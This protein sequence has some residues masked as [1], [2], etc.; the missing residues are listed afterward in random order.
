MLPPI[1]ACVTV[2]E[3]SGRIARRL[4]D[5][6]EFSRTRVRG[7]IMDIKFP[8]D[9]LKPLYFRLKC[10]DGEKQLLDA[11]WFHKERDE[12]ITHLKNELLVVIE[13][14]ITT[15]DQ[16]SSYQIRVDRVIPVGNED[17]KRDREER[18]RRLEKEGVFNKVSKRVIPYLP[19][20][21][22]VVC[23]PTSAAYS[24]IQRWLQ[25]YY[26]A[27]YQLILKP[28][29]VQ[30]EDAARE[31]SAAIESITR[32]SPRPEVVIVARGG[33]AEEDLSVFDDE[34]VVRAAA[35]CQ[36]PLISGVGHDPDEPLIDFAADLRAPTPTAAAAVLQLEDRRCAGREFSSES[37]SELEQ[38]Q[39]FEEDLV[40]DL[41]HRIDE[42]VE[43]LQDVRKLAHDTKERVDELYIHKESPR[44]SK[45][46][47]LMGIAAFVSVVLLVLIAAIWPISDTWAQWP[48]WCQN[49]IGWAPVCK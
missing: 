2:T 12:D 21:I 15:F 42:R 45:V 34:N 33:G 47:T 37:D 28:V 41:R 31:I 25:D 3:I 43:L 39:P 24:D 4:W 13:G 46:K 20:Y 11:V 6:P 38:E 18:W 7:K 48:D 49:Y 35:R 36:V 9:K 16:N 44:G 29:R 26:P 32:E 23:S 22:G 40:P 19:E 8:T 1:E 14:R 17:L 5:H 10:E 27:R 30:G